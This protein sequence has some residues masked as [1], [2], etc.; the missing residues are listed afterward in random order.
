MTHSR[1][2]FFEHLHPATIPA[3]SAVFTYTFGLGG[4]SVLLVLVLLVTGVLLMFLYE[5]SLARAYSSVAAITFE[6]PYGWFVRNLHYWTGQWLVVTVT[7]H[8]ARVVF[9]GGYKRRR[10]NWLIGLGLLVLVI[11]LDFTGLVLRWDADVSW[12]LLVGTNLLREVPLAGETLYRLAVGGETVGAATPVRFYGWHIAGLTIA[13]LFLGVWHLWRVRRDGGISH[14]AHAPR[15]PRRVLVRVEGLAT[16]IVL[17]ALGLVSLLWD[18]PLAPPADLTSP[19]AGES[20]A[21]WFFLGVQEA[22]RVA[23]P[24]LAGVL[25]PLAVLGVLAALP[26]ALD[27]SAEGEGRWFNAAGRRAQIVFAAL[28]LAVIAVTVRGALR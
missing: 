18:A 13:L 17:A 9:T 12:A 7:L 14:A 5:P 15:L 16:L 24:L 26:Y 28:L 3:R 4:I 19:A 21:P 8:M 27:R 22:L 10:A 23:S 1:A 6:A 2:N 20:A 25:A 11:L